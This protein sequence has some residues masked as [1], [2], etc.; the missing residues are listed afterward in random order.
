MADVDLAAV[1]ALIA[2][3][4][5]AHGRLWAGHALVSRPAPSLTV[6]PSLLSALADEVER[7]RKTTEHA[8][9]DPPRKGEPMDMEHLRA[10]KLR[11]A[12]GPEKYQGDAD[13]LISEVLRLRSGPSREECVELVRRLRD[14]INDTPAALANSPDSCALDAADAFLEKYG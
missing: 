13:A 1:R 14:V 9:P 5:E 10:I 12:F 4:R 6:P 8:L 3:A 7:L 2:A 11:W